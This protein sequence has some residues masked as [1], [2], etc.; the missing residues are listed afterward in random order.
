VRVRPTCFYEKIY[1]HLLQVAGHK[2]QDR[3][4]LGPGSARVG[5]KHGDNHFWVIRRHEFN[6]VVCFLI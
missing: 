2:N 4:S 1:Q 5:L 3:V 6:G